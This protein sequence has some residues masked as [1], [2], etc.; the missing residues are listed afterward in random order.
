MTG[1][2][3]AGLAAPAGPPVVRRGNVALVGGKFLVASCFV[4]GAANASFGSGPWKPEAGQFGRWTCF[5][6][7]DDLGRTR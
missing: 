2:L 7:R 3:F 4:C 6:H 5:A 1:D